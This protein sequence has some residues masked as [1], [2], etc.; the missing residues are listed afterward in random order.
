MTAGGGTAGQGNVFSIGMNGTGY[1]N[2]L[3]FNGTNGSQPFGNLTLIGTNLYGMTE[4]GGTS[5]DG[6]LFQHRHQRQRI[7]N[8]CSRSVAPPMAL[9]L[10]MK[11]L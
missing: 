6:T 2:L 10:T 5:S 11:A 4:S 9:I 8:H 7:S 3:S 1:Q